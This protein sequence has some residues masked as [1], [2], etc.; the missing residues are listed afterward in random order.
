MIICRYVDCPGI[1]FVQMM[2]ENFHYHHHF[3]VRTEININEGTRNWKC[4]TLMKF[5]SKFISYSK[6][7]LMIEFFHF[8]MQLFQK[9]GDCIYKFSYSEL[10]FSAK[11]QFCHFWESKLSSLPPCLVQPWS[12]RI[13]ILYR[14]NTSTTMW[15]DKN[16]ERKTH[17]G[18]DNH[19]LK[20]ASSQCMITTYPGHEN[21]NNKHNQLVK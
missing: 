13:S 7:V 6:Y 12:F 11:M 19:I 17:P 10:I 15:L 1:R 20:N 8:E 21:W 5:F 16:I 14:A 18:N 2:I 9:K 4:L 3:Q